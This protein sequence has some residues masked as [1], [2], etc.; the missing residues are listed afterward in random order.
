MTQLDVYQ[1][2]GTKNGTTEVKAEVFGIEPNNHVVA[3][4][5]I[6]QQ[7]S[8]RRGTHA[9]KNRSAVRGGGRKPWRQKGTGRARQGS[10]RAPQWRGGGVVFGPTPRSYAYKL[11]RKVARLAL[12]SVL[13]QKV[14][15]Q[16]MIVV[17]SLDF[18]KPSTKTFKQLLDKLEA[19]GR[20]LVVVESGND[21]AILSARNIDKVK[22]ITVENVNV[23]DVIN[24]QQM[25]VTQKALAK[26]EEAL[27]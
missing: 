14:A 24:N 12:K 15:D 8:L 1:Q 17:D 19:K 3:D 7:A 13:S 26:I 27:G 4:A 16:E 25:I 9:V 21:N 6:M 18:D 22:A 20:T 23:L 11:P 10:I 2:T 5:V